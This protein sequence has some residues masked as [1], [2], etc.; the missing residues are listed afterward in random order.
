[1][2]ERANGPMRAC[3]RVALVLTVLSPNFGLMGCARIDELEEAFL[4]WVESEK[5]PPGRDV[6]YDYL[7]HATPVTSPQ[8][9]P[10]ME[11]SNSKK[12]VKSARRLQRPEVVVPS[13]NENTD[14]GFST[15]AARPE[16]AERQSAP[17]P[18]AS[19]QLPSRWLP[20]PPPDRFSR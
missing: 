8:E 15:E 5:L 7:P 17:P 20:A 3:A 13:S 6:F 19:R 16:G 4:R 1:M 9:P 2:N 11:T 14:P 12:Q 10:K 18:P